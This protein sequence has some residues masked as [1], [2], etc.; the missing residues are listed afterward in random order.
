MVQLA[1]S[2]SR[3]KSAELADE[4][5][6]TPGFLTQVIAPL[7]AK[8]WVQSDPGPTG[9]YSV[10]VSLDN[11]SVL[12]I[13]EAV[14]GPTETGRCVLEDRECGQGMCALHDPWSAARERLLEELGST[15]LA[16]LAPAATGTKQ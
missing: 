8:G 1:Q 7:A 9:G 11:L 2:N 3:S 12:D 6:T 10:T 15:S 4:L 14:E 5:G 16:T 13:I